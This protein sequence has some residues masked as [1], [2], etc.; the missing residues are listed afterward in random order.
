VTQ[1]PVQAD[2]LLTEREAASY[3]SI[4]IYWLQKA[5]CYSYGPRWTRIGGASGRAVR[6]R[7]RDLDAYIE[8]NTV[9]TA[10]SRGTPS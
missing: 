10:D 6:Y 9:E 7:K 1:Y 2:S 8:A 5:R 3:L 4:S